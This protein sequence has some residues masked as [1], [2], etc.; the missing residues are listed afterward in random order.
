L[1]WERVEKCK[2]F[3]EPFCG[4]AAVTLAAPAGAFHHSIVNDLDPLVANVWRALKYKPDEV[5]R[6]IDMPMDHIQIHA[7]R[8]ALE[9]KR[10]EIVAKML[11]DPEWCDPEWAGRVCYQLS[12]YIGSEALEHY[13]APRSLPEGVPHAVPSIANP[14]TISSVKGSGKRSFDGSRYRDWF[15]DLATR[16]SQCAVTCCDWTRLIKRMEAEGSVVFFD[17][18]YSVKER[19]KTYSFD[20]FDVAGKVREWC[21]KN[22][23]AR[24]IYTGYDTECEPL[25][26]T[27]GSD[28]HRWKTNGGYAHQKMNGRGMAN[29]KRECLVFS[30]AFT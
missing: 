28:L 14:R 29:S 26:A 30:P 10:V 18:P 25:A 17:P 20:S 6:A 12:C 15:L 1:I 27:T 4:S 16:L 21:V 2:T 7:I 5:A 11:F 22:Q 13:D 23:R 8:H 24:W 9:D 3:V 19:V